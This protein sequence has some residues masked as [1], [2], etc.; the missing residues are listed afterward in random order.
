MQHA[1]ILAGG[2]GTRLWPA[3]RL[4]RPKQLLK[5]VQ[6]RSLLELAWERAARLVPP[7][8]IWIITAQ[9]YA[10][11]VCTELPH[12][13][14]LNLIGEPIGRD[15]ANA[16]GLATGMIA[17]RDPD[18]TIAVL[19]ADHLV[20]P[21]D[22]FESAVR[23]GL[24]AAERWPAALVTFGVAPSSAN[25]GYGY[26]RRGERTGDGV[27]RVREF[28]EKPGSAQAK[29]YLAAGD[30]YWNS[31]IFAWRA[32]ALIAELSR[33][34]PQ[35]SAALWRLAEELATGNPAGDWDERWASLRPISIDYGVM[36]HAADVR[37]VELAC[38]WTDMGG[39]LS[40]G[41][42]V[43]PDAW[44]NSVLAPRALLEKTTGTIV[45]SDDGH[46][47]VACGLENLVIVHT[48]DATLVC[49]KDH[50]ERLR[51]LAEQRKLQFGERFE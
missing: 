7:T 24:A 12:I 37:M 9:R 41:A 19:T 51:E 8:Q 4:A 22:R 30:F 38:E 50:L 16:I 48:P 47:V 44:G 17:G 33:Q 34:L 43:A 15:T 25:T 39:W 35:N 36:E 29:E 49:H 13:D 40:V 28:R 18:A 26:L 20:T 1:L 23:A 3:S 21:L 46:L 31:G 2:S 10:R 32:S 6:G 27:Y 45:V 5:L 14:P 11:E 42:S